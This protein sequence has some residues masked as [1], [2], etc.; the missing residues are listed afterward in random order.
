MVNG[1]VFKFKYPTIVAD[2]YR[3]RGTVENHNSLS[4]DN[5]TKSQ[6][7]PGSAGGTTCYPT[8]VFLFFVACT[9]V[10]TYLYMKYFLMT[11]ETL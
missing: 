2:N 3:Y 1:E 11:D 4:H 7:G 9:E 8:Q 10:N 5:G 6:I